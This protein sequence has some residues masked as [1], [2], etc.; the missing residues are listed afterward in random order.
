MTT[1]LEKSGVSFQ[2]GMSANCK[3]EAYATTP[4]ATVPAVRFR[5]AVNCW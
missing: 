3:L 1:Q 2:L 4:T 5:D